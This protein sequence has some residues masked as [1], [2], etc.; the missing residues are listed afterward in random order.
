MLEVKVLSSPEALGEFS[1]GGDRSDQV[2]LCCVDGLRCWRDTVLA[3]AGWA[4]T[5]VGVSGGLQGSGLF[6]S[7]CT[8]HRTQLLYSYCRVDLQKNWK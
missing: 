5:G 7:S 8:V 4:V 3:R 6:M 2:E 1:R